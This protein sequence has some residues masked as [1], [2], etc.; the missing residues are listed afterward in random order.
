[1]NRRL[2]LLKQRAD[3]L[4]A[5]SILNDDNCTDEQRAAAL[6]ATILG[7]QRHHLARTSIVVEKRSSRFRFLSSSRAHW[8]YQQPSW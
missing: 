8:S 3:A 4:E 7:V 1:M 5:A 2:K 6:R